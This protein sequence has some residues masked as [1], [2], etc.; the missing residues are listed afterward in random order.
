MALSLA[1]ADGSTRDPHAIAMA[2]LNMLRSLAALRPVLLALDDIQW[3]DTASADVLAFAVRRLR[4]EPVRLLATL[5]VEPHVN[6]P[7]ELDRA[8]PEDRLRRLDIGPL[9]V[10]ALHHLVRARLGV[11]LARPTLHRLRERSGGNPFY[12]LEIARALQRHDDRADLTKEAPLPENLLEFVRA[13]LAL[14]RR[15]SVLFSPWRCWPIRPGR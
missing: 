13:R 4:Q 15:R 7:L 6:V 9:S 3:L 11:E 1:D 14:P 10:G 5:R 12:A 2:F 8:L